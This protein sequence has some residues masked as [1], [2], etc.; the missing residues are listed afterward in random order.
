[1]YYNDGPR[2]AGGGT[3]GD[4]L[5]DASRNARS[6]L[7]RDPGLKGHRSALDY[8]VFIG[9]ADGE[10]LELSIPWVFTGTLGLEIPGLAVEATHPSKALE[11]GEGS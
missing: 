2:V 1:V 9:L 6:F 10:R 5:H 11:A 3:R 7:L 8:S 4:R